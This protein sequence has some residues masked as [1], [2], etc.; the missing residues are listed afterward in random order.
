MTKSFLLEMVY[1]A[2]ILSVPSPAPKPT[3]KGKLV[4]RVQFRV[5]SAEQPTEEPE[6]PEA[7]PTE[8]HKETRRVRFAEEPQVQEQQ[9]EPEDDDGEELI[10]AD[11][12]EDSHQQLKKELEPTKIQ[13]ITEVTEKQP[14]VQ[15]NGSTAT[16]EEPKGMYP[17]RKSL[18]DVR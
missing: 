11:E 12:E 2:H 4:R 1:R 8:E 15:E 9:P 6:Q 13:E 14:A 3:T 10:E 5:D 18:N 17:P 7:A 16:A